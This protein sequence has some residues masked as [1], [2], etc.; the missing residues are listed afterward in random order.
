MAAKQLFRMALTNGIDFEVKD[1]EL[2]RAVS[3][4]LSLADV[5][6]IHLHAIFCKVNEKQRYNIRPQD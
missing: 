1:T 5:Q 2:P 3:N 4:A 6:D